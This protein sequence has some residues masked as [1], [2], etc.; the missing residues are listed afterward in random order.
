MLLL[1]VLWAALRAERSKTP[2]PLRV[3]L[4]TELATTGILEL[5]V[6]RLGWRSAA[7]GLIY[8]LV[9]PLELIAALNLAKPSIMAGF[10]ALLCSW[11]VYLTAGEA[12]T[13]NGAIALIEGCFFMLAGLSLGFKMPFEPDK[14][15]YGPLAALW[16][17]LALFDFGFAMSLHLSAWANLN[18]WWP[19]LCCIVVFGWIGLNHR[20]RPLGTG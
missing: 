13:V 14:L 3:Y 1:A 10:I 9:R 12:V 2:K 18:E 17:F 8:V 16:L 15:I 6:W 4:W 5:A 7:Y 19:A 11:A 20:K